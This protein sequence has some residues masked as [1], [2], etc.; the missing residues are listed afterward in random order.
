MLLVFVLLLLWGPIGAPRAL[1]GTVAILAG[2]MAGTEALRRQVLEE[3]AGADDA[4]AP[5]PPPPTP[6]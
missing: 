6:A 3:G 1:I 4:S 2:A 5:A